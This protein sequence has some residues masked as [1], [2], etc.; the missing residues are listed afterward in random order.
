M[1]RHVLQIKVRKEQ[2]N[3]NI[4]H[5]KINNKYIF[6]QFCLSFELLKFMRRSSASNSG[7]EV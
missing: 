3:I 2:N 6:S 5:N 7:F 4:I 1:S